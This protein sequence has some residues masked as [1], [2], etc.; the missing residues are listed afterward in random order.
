MAEC[1]ITIGLPEVLSVLIPILSGGFEGAKVYVEGA[2]P[3]VDD[4]DDRSVTLSIAAM[5]DTFK[6]RA[7]SR[8]F[9]ATR[10]TGSPRQKVAELE[11]CR[12][13]VRLVLALLHSF[14]PVN[15]DTYFRLRPLG[16]YTRVPGKGSDDV[17]IR[18]V[19]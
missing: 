1:P 16:D 14:S 19:L 17:R 18:L 7:P 10:L 9:D 12:E 5:P 13:G 6:G 8:L 3:I 15:S 11:T 4:A 2:D